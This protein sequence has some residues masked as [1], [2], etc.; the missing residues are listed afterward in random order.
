MSSQ[1]LGA[2]DMGGA[3]TEITFAPENAAAMNP[4]FRETVELFGKHY[5]V[6][7]Y[8]YQCY[9][10]NEAYRRYLSHL[11]QVGTSHTSYR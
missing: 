4:H 9:G 1:T 5:E 3:S 8:S 11:V 7:S 10:V 2:L 6:Y